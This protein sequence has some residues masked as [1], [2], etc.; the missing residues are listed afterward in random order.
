MLSIYRARELGENDAVNKLLYNT[1][2]RSNRGHAEMGTFKPHQIKTHPDRDG[3]AMN[4]LS[5]KESRQGGKGYRVFTILII[6]LALAMV[7]WL[8]VEIYGQMQPTPGFMEDDAL[9][10]VSTEQQPPASATGAE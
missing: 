1:L 3:A 9:P 4:E 6:S 2:Q 8:A 7:V 5:P 10:P